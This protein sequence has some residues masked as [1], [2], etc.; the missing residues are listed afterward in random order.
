[1]PA[2][3]TLRGLLAALPAPVIVFCKSHSGSRFLVRV[4]QESSV[5]MGSHINEAGDAWDLLPLTRHLVIH[6]DPDYALALAGAD[7]MLEDMVLAAIGG[8]LEGWAAV[9]GGRWGW[10]L[11]ETTFALPVFARLFPA[12]RFVHLLR[13]GRDAAFSDH[14][15]PTDAFWRKVILGRDEPGLSPGIPLDGPGYRRRPHLINARH[16]RRSVGRGHD[17]VAAHGAACLEIRY[18]DLCLDFAATVERLQ[19]F[20]DL[21]ARPLSLGPDPALV[22]ASIGKYRR[23]PRREV[24]QALALIA[25]LQAAL[26]YGLAER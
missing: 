18:E 25:P 23:R 4:L 26:G 3:E 15:G 10:K 9:D 24:Q 5:F 2:A 20:L 22:Q 12:A 11:C 7:P 13:D 6:H 16:W 14:T 1:L 21:P 17:F 19:A 8:H